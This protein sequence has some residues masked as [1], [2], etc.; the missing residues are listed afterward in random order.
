MPFKRKKIAAVFLAV[1]M[2][3]AMAALPQISRTQAAVYSW[4]SS[5]PMVTKI[6]NNL[7]K[8][9]YYSGA[10]DGVFG[11]ETSRAVRQFQRKNGLAVDGIVGSSTL[12]ALGLS[13][14]SGGGSAAG[15]QN[16]NLYLLARIIS[17]EARGEPYEGQ[18]AVGA[19]VLNRVRHPSF[20]NSLSGVIYQNGAFTAIVDGQFDQPISSSAYRAARDA[21][22]GWDPSGGAIYYYNPVKSTSKWIFSRP[23]IKTIGNHVFAK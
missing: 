12:A 8:W 14:S 16:S 3:F 6:Q 5:G 15:N 20:P 23:V 2:L 17:A 11:G 19:V 9:G 4:G 7:K 22:N 18:V 1:L 13:G 10:V 21:M